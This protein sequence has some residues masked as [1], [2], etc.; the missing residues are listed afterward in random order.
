MHLPMEV[1]RFVDFLSSTDHAERAGRAFGH[2]GLPLDFY[3]L[4]IA[5]NGR[6]SFV[7]VSGT[8]IVRPTVQS[9]PEGESETPNWGPCAALDFELE[10]VL[11]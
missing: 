7:V 9:R 2:N 3:H 11:P 1:K 10:M 5:Y 4:P 6:A 8:E